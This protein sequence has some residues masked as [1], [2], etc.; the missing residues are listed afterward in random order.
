[1]QWSVQRCVLDRNPSCPTIGPP[2]GASRA[3]N[4]SAGAVAQSPSAQAEALH[5]MALARFSDLRQPAGW[6]IETRSGSH[7]RLPARPPGRRWSWGSCAGNSAVLSAVRPFGP[8][9]RQPAPAVRCHCSCAD[10]AWHD[11]QSYIKGSRSPTTL[12][13]PRRIRPP[14]RKGRSDSHA[15]G[16]S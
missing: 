11:G 7:A 9:R 1:L 13:G 14:G 5:G 6:R 10:R 4:L 2:V 16:C 15:G 8:G 12:P 3:D